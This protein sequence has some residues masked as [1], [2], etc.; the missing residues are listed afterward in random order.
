MVVQKQIPKIIPLWFPKEKLEYKTKYH[1]NVGIIGK[2]SVGKYYKGL[3]VL[4]C[5][6]TFFTKDKKAFKYVPDWFRKRIPK[7]EHLDGVLYIKDIPLEN[8]RI[9]PFCDEKFKDLWKDVIF[10]VH[11]MKLDDMIFD[12]RYKSLNSLFVKKIRAPFIKKVE[13][14][15]HSNIQNDFYKLNAMYK[16]FV[17]SNECDGIRIINFHS[18]YKK[19]ITSNSFLYQK[20][21]NGE[22]IITDLCEGSGQYYRK[23]GK[24]KCKLLNKDKYFYCE[25][26]IPHELKLKYIFDKTKCIYQE[27]DSLKVGDVINFSCSEILSSGIPRESFFRGLK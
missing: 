11:D 13:F 12:S 20:E 24:I 25:K 8:Y 14:K 7:G 17:E 1:E 27:E 26:G 22:A 9:L 4:W 18:K 19:G 2:W 6:N 16:E 15:L 3:E 23:L 21:F 10:Y 5:G